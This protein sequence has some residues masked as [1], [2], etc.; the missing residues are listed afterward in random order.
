MSAHLHDLIFAAASAV[1]LL[2]MLPAVLRAVLLPLSTCIITGGGV[3]VLAIN[4]ATM[5]YWYAM[6]IAVANATC[7]AYLFSVALRSTPGRVSSAWTRWL[8]AGD[9]RKPTTAANYS[10]PFPTRAARRAK[11]AEC[12]AEA[13][14][15]EDDERYAMACRVTETLGATSDGGRPVDCLDVWLSRRETA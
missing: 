5:G 13:A 6:A 7:W 4:Y 14:R 1:L 12:G 9:A 2:A 8:D 10:A 3:F 15:R 11:P